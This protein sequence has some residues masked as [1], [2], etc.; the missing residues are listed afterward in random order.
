MENFSSTVCDNV[1]KY[2]FFNTM[3][4]GSDISH[5]LGNVTHMGGSQIWVA[6][7]RLNHESSIFWFPASGG[8]FP[9]LFA[10]ADIV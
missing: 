7:Q 10:I 8:G 3:Y 9:L 4:E 1:I 6:I 2:F 5:Q